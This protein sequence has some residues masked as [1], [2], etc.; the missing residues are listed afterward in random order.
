MSPRRR[1]MAKLRESLGTLER[2][3]AENKV[4]QNRSNILQIVLVALAVFASVAIVFASST[5]VMKVAV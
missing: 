4:Q 5:A 3:S 1:R 2:M